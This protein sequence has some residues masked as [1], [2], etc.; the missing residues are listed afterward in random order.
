[1]A[2]NQSGGRAMAQTDYAANHFVIQDLPN[3][4]R[5]SYTRDGLSQTILVGEK[6]IDPSI[7][8]GVSWFWDEPI[9]IG[10]SK[11]TARA[12]LRIVTDRIGASFRDN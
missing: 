9:Y 8:T 6:A 3:I 12:G 4:V 1:M 7:Q 11:G 5:W 2:F 10:G